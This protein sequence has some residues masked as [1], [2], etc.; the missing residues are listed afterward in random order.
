MLMRDNKNFPGKDMGNC[1]SFREQISPEEFV[2]FL[3]EGRAMLSSPCIYSATGC[4]SGYD[5]KLHNSSISQVIEAAHGLFTTQTTDFPSYGGNLL[6]ANFCLPSAA[7]TISIGRII[8]CSQAGFPALDGQNREAIAAAI[9]EADKALTIPGYPIHFASQPPPSCP[10]PLVSCPAI[11]PNA[12]AF[13]IVLIVFMASRRC[14]T[15][16][17][18]ALSLTCLPEL[19]FGSSVAALSFLALMDLIKF[20]GLGKTLLPG[21]SLLATTPFHLYCGK[22]IRACYPGEGKVIKACPPGFPLGPGWYFPK[23]KCF[24]FYYSPKCST[25]KLDALFAHFLGGDSH[26]YRMAPSW[27]RKEIKRFR[28]CN[29]FANEKC[30]PRK[31]LSPPPSHLSCSSRSARSP[32]SPRSSYA[33]SNS[34]STE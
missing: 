21:E 25:P 28:D 9:R 29:P 32:R 6:V 33:S 18:Q 16:A 10:A 15:S 5:L 31:S 30:V 24:P 23:R 1:S 34:Y 22:V 11:T 19:F 27:L 13:M 14:F 26:N 17:G 8:P 4:F 2:R 20:P 7:G 12:I 3:M